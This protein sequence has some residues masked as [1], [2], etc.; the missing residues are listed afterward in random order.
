MCEVPLHMNNK[1]LSVKYNLDART[2]LHTYIHTYVDVE[3][4][5]CM[6]IVNLFQ[7]NHNIVQY[8]RISI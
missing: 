1:L 8:I 7:R 6:K 2:Y 3:T 4:Y 5:M